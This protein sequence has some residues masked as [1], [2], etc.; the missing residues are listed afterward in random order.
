MSLNSSPDTPLVPAVTTVKKDWLQ[1]AL[2]LLL[3]IVII[4]ARCP[5]L[6]SSPRFWAEEGEIYF[7]AAYHYGFWQA[8]F[9]EH[10]GYYELVANVATAFSTFV[11]LEQA[12]F[13]TTYIAFLLQILVSAVVIFGDSPFWDTWPKKVMIAC[14]IQLI[15]P[16][17]V[18]LT[19]ISAH[20]WL[21][22]ATFFILN[23]R[24]YVNSRIRQNFHR[25]ILVM[26][27]LSSVVSIFL[28]PLFLLKAW[29][30]RLRESWIQTGILATALLIQVCAFITYL[31]MLN[32]LQTRSRLGNNAFS[33]PRVIMRHFDGPFFDWDL[34]KF[35]PEVCIIATLY[36]LMIFLL[37]LALRSVSEKDYLTHFQAFLLV[38]VPSTLLSLE[39]TSDHR[40]V[41]A[42]SA[43]LF[44][45]LVN[46]AFNR[47]KKYSRWLALFFV[48]IISVS[49]ISRFRSHIY[50]QDPTQW[51]DE[52]KSWQVNPGKPLK[53]WPQWEQKSWQV[54]LTPKN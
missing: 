30:N 43:M 18:W 5:G 7:S 27:G 53:I 13:V 48:T 20:F 26:A 34:S 4:V 44:V 2:L 12:P 1:S 6:L 29:R 25:V 8:L 3:V 37:Y 46:E 52:V 23:E 22:I 38:A 50:S 47:K 49:C 51:R 14:G 32:S 36:G 15:N 39:M 21:C 40:Y 35:I 33:L 11:P 24:P 41:F 45:V 10:V 54:I 19:T 31:L 9:L 17:E 28:I 16:F 42:P